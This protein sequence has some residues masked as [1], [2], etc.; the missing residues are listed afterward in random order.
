LAIRCLL[1]RMARRSRKSPPHARELVAL[2]GYSRAWNC[3]DPERLIRSTPASTSGNCSWVI[4][5]GPE[6]PDLLP[7]RCNDP[8]IAA[9][10][11]ISIVLH[12]PK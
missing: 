1:W 7:Q 2:L 11:S 10:S 9:F 5:R 4:A 8:M 6:R 3:S 12:S